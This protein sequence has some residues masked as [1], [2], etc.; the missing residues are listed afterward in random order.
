MNAKVKEFNKGDF[1]KIRLAG[2]GHMERIWA[3]VVSHE[4]GEVTVRIDNHPINP[5]FEFNEQLTIPPEFILEHY[6]PKE[7]DE[8][9]K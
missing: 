8:L 9:K 5:D 2:K 3:E 6:T 1:V 7:L 4:N